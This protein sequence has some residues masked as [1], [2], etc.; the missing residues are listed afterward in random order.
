MLFEYWILDVN[1]YVNAIV[2]EI[3]SLGG[4]SVLVSNSMHAS[5][6]P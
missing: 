5:V 4:S 1:V 2:I 6:E 3:H